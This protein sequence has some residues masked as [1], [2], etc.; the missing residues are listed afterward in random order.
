MKLVS[1]FVN[2]KFQH[3]VIDVNLKVRYLSK[4][5]YLDKY[6]LLETA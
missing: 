4:N 1:L 2:V 3:W 5:N 6:T